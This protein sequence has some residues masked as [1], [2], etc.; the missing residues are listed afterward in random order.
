MLV[1][2]HLIFNCYFCS[3]KKVL[4]LVV[5]SVFLSSVNAQILINEYSGANYDTYQDNYGEYEDWLELYN[6]TAT[7]VDINC[8]PCATKSQT[9]SEWPIFSL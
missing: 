3:M 4:Y 9:V 5:F 6:P 2:G 8:T 7:Q 1:I